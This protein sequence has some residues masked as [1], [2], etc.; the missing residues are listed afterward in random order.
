MCTAMSIREVDV[1][2]FK[3]MIERCGKDLQPD[4]D[5]WPFL[6]L[7]K[8]K[9]IAIVALPSVNTEVEKDYAAHIIKFTIMITNPDAAC[10]ISTG[11]EGESLRNRFMDIEDFEEAYKQGWVTRPS[12]DPDRKEIVILTMMNKWKEVGFLMGYI[13]RRKDRAPM[14]RKWVDHSGEG[15]TIGGRFG[16]A[17]TEGFAS[18]DPNGNLEVL[19]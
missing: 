14:I 5:W 17:L 16:D 9:K 2:H 18:T 8:D 6:F 1:E 11:W 4:E 19:D 13:K 12:E 3:G 10:Y 15:H 7:V